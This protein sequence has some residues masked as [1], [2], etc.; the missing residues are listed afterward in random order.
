MEVLVLSRSCWGGF[1]GA[2]AEAGAGGGHLLCTWALP[3]VIVSGIKLTTCYR[4]GRRCWFWFW[5]LTGWFWFWLLTGWFWFWLL[6]GWFWFWLLTVYLCVYMYV[7][8]F[9]CVNIWTVFVYLCPDIWEASAFQL[10]AAS[11]APNSAANEN[12]RLWAA[13]TQ[14]WSFLERKTL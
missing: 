7:Y 10:L 6:T 1:Q 14:M 5:L 2:A 13:Q 9:V 3:R 12:R 8:I 4:L 11:W